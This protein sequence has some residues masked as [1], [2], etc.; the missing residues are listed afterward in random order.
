M[1]GLD[2]FTKFEA[3]RVDGEYICGVMIA[4]DFKSL[5]SKSNNYKK[6][7]IYGR[8]VFEEFAIHVGYFD[9]FTN[10][11]WREAFLYI[12]GHDFIKASNKCIDKSIKEKLKQFLRRGIDGIAYEGSVID[13]GEILY[14]SKQSLIS[15]LCNAFIESRMKYVDKAKT[16]QSITKI[17]ESCDGNEFLIYSGYN[18]INLLGAIAIWRSF[19]DASK[20]NLILFSEVALGVNLFDKVI[21]RDFISKHYVKN[22]IISNNLKSYDER[23][24]NK[25]ETEYSYRKESFP[26]L[27]SIRESCRLIEKYFNKSE[28]DSYADD[29]SFVAPSQKPSLVRFQSNSGIIDL[30]NDATLDP[31]STYILGAAEALYDICDDLASSSSIGNIVPSFSKKMSRIQNVI[32]DIRSGVFGDNNIIRLGV[33]LESLSDFTSVYKDEL[34]SSSVKEITFF[35]SRSVAFVSQFAVWSEYK[36]NEYVGLGADTR[37]IADSL[38]Y[39]ASIESNML[40]PEARIAIED[41]R[42]ISGAGTSEIV[43]NSTIS[44]AENMV[45]QASAIVSSGENKDV[46]EWARRNSTD[47]DRLGEVSSVGWLRM[48]AKIVGG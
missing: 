41:V 28:I 6:Y 16:L 14:F 22:F 48:F 39:S 30:L 43:A 33:E 46:S 23:I 34:S 11:Y 8:D 9:N 3:K 2:H 29:D 47:I 7:N 24:F 26:D 19:Q 12:D 32:G 35:I 37:K 10:R 42:V 20:S 4:S 31:N 21:E 1:A 36:K 38:I 44:V 15:F 5:T 13:L 18:Q 17:V 45:A 40:S 25:V 27:L